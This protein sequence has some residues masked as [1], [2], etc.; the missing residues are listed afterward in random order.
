MRHVG[1]LYDGKHIYE[2]FF[3][4]LPEVVFQEGW[5][6]HQWDAQPSNGRPEPFTQGMVSVGTIFTDIKFDI[7]T[8]SLS[9]DMLDMKD[10]VV[11]LGWENTDTYGEQEYPEKRL[12][13]PWGISKQIFADL[14]YSRE[15][16]IQY[17]QI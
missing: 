17:K 9:F 15:I 2:F 4:D 16:P 12:V 3:S 7:L 14:L 6:N 5:Q 10:G 8:E 11:A 13:F 1:E